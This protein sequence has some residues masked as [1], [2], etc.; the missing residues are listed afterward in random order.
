MRP[1]VVWFGEA[2]ESP[3]LDK[4]FDL[5]G[6]CDICLVVGTSSVSYL[7]DLAGSSSDENGSGNEAV[8][9]HYRYKSRQTDR[10]TK[11][12]VGRVD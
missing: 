4:A 2:L 1:H 11:S 12:R 10:Q 9:A 7:F 3:V 6:E 5:I 8:T